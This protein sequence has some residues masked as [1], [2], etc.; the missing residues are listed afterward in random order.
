MA[1]WAIWLAPIALCTFRC[2][3]LPKSG[4]QWRKPNAEY[5]SRGVLLAAVCERAFDFEIGL[6][7]ERGLFSCQSSINRSYFPVNSLF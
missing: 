3:E 1:A 5:R 7:T 4:A 2:P 6:W